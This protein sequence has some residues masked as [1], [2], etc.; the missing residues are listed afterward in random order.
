MGSLSDSRLERPPR[1]PPRLGRGQ[2]PLARS[3][4]DHLGPSDESRHGPLAPRAAASPGCSRRRG[5]G[6]AGTGSRRAFTHGGSRD[7]ETSRRLEG[8]QGRVRSKTSRGRDVDAR[9]T[10]H[11]RGRSSSSDSGLRDSEYS[12]PD[13]RPVTDHY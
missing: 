8:V 3:A 13:A 4:S 11:W 9:R 7:F 6:A 12:L 2:R 1:R 5:G 10:V